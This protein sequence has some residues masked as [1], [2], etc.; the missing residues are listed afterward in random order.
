MRIAYNELDRSAVRVDNPAP[1][2]TQRWVV[3]ECDEPTVEVS[4]PRCFTA[5]FAGRIENTEAKP[6]VRVCC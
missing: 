4:Y 1:I 6:A 3:V 2:L 5:V